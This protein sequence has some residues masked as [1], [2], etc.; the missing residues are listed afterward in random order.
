[1][2]TNRSIS[3][4]NPFV[5][6]LSLSLSQW[7]FYA[8]VMKSV[9]T[10]P[11]VN[12]VILSI[13]PQ[14]KWTSPCSPLTHHLLP[15]QSRSYWP[16][17]QRL[18]LYVCFLLLSSLKLLVSLKSFSLDPQTTNLEQHYQ[19]QSMPFMFSNYGFCRFFT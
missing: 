8:C 2:F 13:G 3:S 16:T 4:C 6:S 10:Q 17:P 18:C 7:F 9:P 14:Y 19:K 15:S 5:L 11:P 12:K 1:M